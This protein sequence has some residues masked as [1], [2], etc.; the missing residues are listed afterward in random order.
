MFVD[1]LNPVMGDI[2]SKMELKMKDIRDNIV[3]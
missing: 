2:N 3:S 1:M